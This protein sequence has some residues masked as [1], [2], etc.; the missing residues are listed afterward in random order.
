VST[1]SL[2]ISTGLHRPTARLDTGATH[3]FLDKALASTVK[4]PPGSAAVSLASPETSRP[5]PPQAQV[6]LE[7]GGTSPLREAL[8][9]SPLD[10]APGLDSILGWD[11]I[12]SHDLHFLYP[13]GAVAGRSPAGPLHIRYFLHIPPFPPKLRF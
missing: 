8:D 4:Q 9:M 6:L 1:G 12:A 3:C 10:L 5:L 7:L 2:W 13:H 11:W